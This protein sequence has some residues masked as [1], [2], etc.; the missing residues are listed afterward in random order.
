MGFSHDSPT[1]VEA[2]MSFYIHSKFL[3]IQNKEHLDDFVITLY[4]TLM[5][6]IKNE[7]INV[8]SFSVFHTEATVIKH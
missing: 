1:K 5:H 8:T 6:L 4:F 3:C 2:D 7:F